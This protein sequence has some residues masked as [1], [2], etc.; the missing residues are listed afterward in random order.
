[1]LAEGSR[2]VGKMWRELSKEERVKYEALAEKDR[3]RYRKEMVE[4]NTNPEDEEV[5]A[6]PASTKKRRTLN[7][8]GNR[9]GKE[10]IP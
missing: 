2:L 1:M 9:K 10:K 7:V 6:P 5:S 4:Y 3:Q 8:K